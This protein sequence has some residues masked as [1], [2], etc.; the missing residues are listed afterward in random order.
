MEANGGARLQDHRIPVLSAFGR[1]ALRSTA[2]LAASLLLG[3][4]VAFAYP[5]SGTVPGA[6]DGVV[7]DTNLVALSG[8]IAS[9]FGAPIQV[10]TG[11]N[12]RFRIVGLPAGQYI[13]VV[14]H[15]GYAPS[16]AVMQVVS[17]DR[18]RMSFTLRPVVNA[19][20]TVVIAG[21]R[22]SPKMTEF[23]DRRKAGYGQFMTQAEIEKRNSV[24]VGDLVRTFQS[25]DIMEGKFSQVAISHRFGRYGTFSQGVCPLQVFLDGVALPA[26]TNLNDLPSPKNLAGIEVYSGPATIPLQYKTSTGGF[27][28]VILVWTK[29]GS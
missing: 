3:T 8:A 2:V 14:R 19:L 6:I 26:P 11:V 17:G 7:S 25:I 23:E 21:K 9:L 5:Q 1:S 12:G 28:G 10:V 4:G 20:D 13:L 18:L 27:C 22:L 15:L 29:D 16:S 24:L